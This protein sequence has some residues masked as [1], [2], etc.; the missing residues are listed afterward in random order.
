MIII[1]VNIDRYKSA[2]GSTTI[3]IKHIS[4]GRLVKQHGDIEIR[5]EEQYSD[6]QRERL[7]EL[8]RWQL[9]L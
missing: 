3:R 9:T 2:A 5:E 7:L 1:D 4:T 6:G 8:M